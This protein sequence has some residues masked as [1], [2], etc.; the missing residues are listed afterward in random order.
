MEQASPIRMRNYGRII[1]DMVN[2]V[3]TMPE[4]EDREALVVALGS[5]MITRNLLWNKDQESSP[6]RVCRDLQ[7]L[8][9]GK[10][11]LTPEALSAS[12]ERV[13]Q[14]NRDAAQN[15]RGNGNFKK[16]KR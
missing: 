10:I 11:L 16:N 9:D 12:M 8:S 15:R 5:A 4:S 1:Q 3:S 13:R 2:H 6:E 14:N 7:T